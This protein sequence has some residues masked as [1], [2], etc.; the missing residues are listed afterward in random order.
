MKRKI[1]GW[2]PVVLLFCVAVSVSCAEG[3]SDPFSED[4]QAKSLDAWMR[5]NHPEL[6]A[7]Y[8]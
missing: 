6:V 2:L 5:M 1:E 7:N 3:V 8:Q 4:V